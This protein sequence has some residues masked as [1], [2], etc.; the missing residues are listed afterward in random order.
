[1][2]TVSPEQYQGFC[3]MSFG[4]QILQGA[5]SVPIHLRKKAGRAFS[6]SPILVECSSDALEIQSH[7][8]TNRHHW[9]KVGCSKDAYPAVRWGQT[10]YECAFVD[11]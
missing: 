11:P 7:V 5:Q 1:M 2:N 6:G 10:W 9:P 4:V 3:H 8:R